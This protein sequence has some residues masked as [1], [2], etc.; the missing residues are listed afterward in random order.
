MSELSLLR[1]LLLLS[2]VA[3]PFGTQRFLAESARLRTVAH[4][5]AFVCA[6][7]G[8]FAPFPTLCVAWLLFCA[9]SFAL[10]FDLMR[11]RC[12]CRGCSQR[13]SHSSSATS[14]R[15]G[16]SEAQTTFTSS[17]T[18]RTSATT[19]HCTGT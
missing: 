8:L 2:M 6:A 9:A 10:F 14:R 12:A 5:G 17:G 13:V 7:A 1:G 15:C 18:A 4:I 3:G 19:L 11:G 16:S